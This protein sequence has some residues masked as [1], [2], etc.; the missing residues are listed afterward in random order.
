MRPKVPTE[1]PVAIA[2]HETRAVLADA[3]TASSRRS[4]VSGPAAANRSVLSITGRMATPSRQR[5]PDRGEPAAPARPAAPA[6]KKRAR[7]PRTVTRDAHLTG[8]SHSPSALAARR[9]RQQRDHARG[10]PAAPKP[11]APEPRAPEP[12]RPVLDA[13]PPRSVGASRRDRRQGDRR[14]RCTAQR[15]TSARATPSATCAA[16]R[17][18][19]SAAPAARRRRRSPGRPRDDRDVPMIALSPT[20]TPR[21]MQAP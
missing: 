19:G 2:R 12:P 1:H 14:D 7:V 20:V 9:Q 4:P 16:A 6:A 18:C 5:A 10:R 3:H 8:T 11:R 17:A 21:R 13:E 15:R